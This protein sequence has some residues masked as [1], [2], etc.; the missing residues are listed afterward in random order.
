[1]YGSQ[2]PWFE[3]FRTLHAYDGPDAYS[4]LLERWPEEHKEE[5]HWIAGFAVRTEGC[6]CTA[7]GEDLCRLYAIYRVTSTLLLRFQVG[8]ADGV[9]YPGPGISS[10]GFQFFHEA[11]GLRVPEIA[12]VHP[13]FHEIVQVQQSRAAETPISIVEQRWPPLMLGSM[14]FCRGGVAVAGG[15][16]Y[17]VKDVAEHSKLYWTFRR[18]DRRHEDLSHGWGSNSQWRTPFRRDIQLPTGFHY[19]IDAQESLNAASGTI[20]GLDVPVLIE[21]VRHRCLIRTVVDDSDL[22]PYQ[23]TYAEAA[24]GTS[25]RGSG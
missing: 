23:Y 9:D 25:A 12:E 10:E 20:E 5:C 11:L 7:T 19:N 15:T 16:A 13:F 22:F 14:M 3:L 18:K 1:M 6:W 21:L 24:E 8:R 4:D 2:W 17:V